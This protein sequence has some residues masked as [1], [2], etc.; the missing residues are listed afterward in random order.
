MKKW[1]MPESPIDVEEPKFFKG[2]IVGLAVCIP[3]WYVVIKLIISA[4]Q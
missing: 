1:K 3:I 4:I 2:V